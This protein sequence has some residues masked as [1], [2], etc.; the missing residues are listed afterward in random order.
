MTQI[1]DE[2]EEMYSELRTTRNRLVVKSNDLVQKA[3]FQL[4]T[5]E[6]KI[7]LY[8][9]SKIKPDEDEFIY[10]DFNIA[11]FCRVCGIDGTNGGN[12]KALKNTIKELSDKSLWVMLES[13]TETLMRWINKAWINKKS[14]NIRL[15]L[16]DDMK[17]YLL[18]LQE[19]FTQ[20][21]LLYTLAMRS[22]YSIR[23]YELL[24]SYEY[25]KHVVLDLEELKRLIC[26][27]NYIRYPDFKRYVLDIS[28]REINDLSDL[29]V[30]YE[31]I[32]V[33]RKYGKIEF[34]MQIKKDME[35]RLRT[36]AR[37]DEV[38]NPA[39]LSLFDRVYGQ[40]YNE[41]GREGIK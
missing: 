20:Y 10:Q 32:K 35:E 9:I 2:S 17:P 31:I 38:I 28:M 18:Q 5:Q 26:A 37:I 21:E 25:K 27:E 14:G 36:W 12:Y 41:P 33:G 13:G 1:K 30:T 15:R 3:R 6:Q 34:I 19:R 40:K 7:I 4:S 39:Q 11:E 22:Q 16:D 23:L 24:K 8:M 29:S